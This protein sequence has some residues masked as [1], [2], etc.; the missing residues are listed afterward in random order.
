[1]NFIQ[2]ICLD[3]PF[4]TNIFLAEEAALSFAMSVHTHNLRVMETD[5]TCFTSTV[6]LWL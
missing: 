4:C 5:I 6:P 2:M 3:A 1:M